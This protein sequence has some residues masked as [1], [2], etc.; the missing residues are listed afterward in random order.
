[1]TTDRAP[2]PLGP[3]C[4]RIGPSHAFGSADCPACRAPRVPE[5]VLWAF[6]HFYHLDCANAKIHCAPVRFS[7]LTFRLAESLESAWR[8]GEDWTQE[9][10]HVLHDR[11]KYEEDPGR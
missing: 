3:I 11:G 4:N 6:E 7:P 1:M 2:E 10:A 8:D 5:S 9:L